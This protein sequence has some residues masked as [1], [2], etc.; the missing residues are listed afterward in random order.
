MAETNKIRYSGSQTN[1]KR[2]KLPVMQDNL[3]GD[4][5]QILPHLARLN[6]KIETLRWI[7]KQLD[8]SQ[9]ELFVTFRDG[10]AFP[11]DEII[12]FNLNLE[13][14]NLIGD[15]IDEY[16]R[17]HDNLNKLSDESSR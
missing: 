15:S 5:S 13:V 1:F 4:L 9:V 6:E 7:S 17:Q 2:Q 10:T 14:K 11:L 12:P 16:Q 8:E 3:F